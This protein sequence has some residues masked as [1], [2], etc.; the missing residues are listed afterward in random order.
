MDGERVALAQVA[1]EIVEQV[2]KTFGE[3]RRDPNAPIRP[4][5]KAEERQWSFGSVKASI[6][7]FE[8][9]AVRVDGGRPGVM[10][11]HM[12]APLRDA[13]VDYLA[14]RNDVVKTIHDGL[15]KLDL[16]SGQIEAPELNGHVFANKA[17]LLGAL[18]D[19]GNES[20]L[21]KRLLGSK[22]VPQPRERDGPI[23]TAPFWAFFERMI[24]DRKI[25]KADVDFLQLFWNSYHE[26]FERTQKVHFEVYGYQIPQLDRRS[27]QT[28]WG[29]YEGGYVPAKP[30][31]KQDPS[32]LAR[33][34]GDVSVH[35]TASPIPS[36]GRDFAHQRVEVNRSLV[37]NIRERVEHFDEHLRFLH[38]QKPGRQVWRLLQ[39]K[40]LRDE[41]NRIDPHIIPGIIR[42]WIKDTL[43]NRVMK[44]GVNRWLDKILV[45]IR[46]N[47]GQLYMMGNVANAA[48]QATGLVAAG[49]VA[50]LRNAKAAS[51]KFVSNPREYVQ[52]VIELSKFMDLRLVEQMGQIVDDIDVV[53]KPNLLS[54][55]QHWMSR[56]AYFLQRLIQSPVDVITWGA[57][58]DHATETGKS[59]KDAVQEA[60]SAVR[61]TQGSGL[62]PDLSAAERAGALGRM[63]TQFGSI[64]FVF[65]NLTLE[66]QT[67]P[68]RIQRFATLTAFM[69]VGAAAITQAL[70]GGWDDE[71][72]DGALMDDVTRWAFGEA[73]QSGAAIGAPVVGPMLS[74][75]L[76]DERSRGRLSFGASMGA[77]E[78]AGRGLRAS[79]QLLTDGTVLDSKPDIAREVK[80]RDIRDIFTLFG[81]LLGAPPA[82][83]VK[84]FGF[85]RDVERGEVQPTSDFDYW[86]GL[87]TGSASPGSR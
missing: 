21:R 76:F 54:R 32:A 53:L 29:V 10:H 42:P 83:A 34:D 28:P 85:L 1:G 43:L 24:E 39:N 77:I 15:N 7:H 49:F 13:H 14:E 56:N 50:P 47:V 57:V 70:R 45:T 9:F 18:L 27:F 87:V 16:P 65:W 66:G 23:N 46:R 64:W 4:L 37:S 38:M 74:R 35:D 26:R 31:P 86:R 69:G 67:T 79:F 72:A 81:L 41:L 25:T 62:A 80:G 20:N 60:D 30:D 48:Q 75:M 2:Q 22:W 51:A 52:R 17:E 11:K 63:L 8:S 61:R 44:P 59:Q 71:D 55:S 3:D 6:R 78:T 5:T 58:Y 36:T 73:V 12:F 33:G 82:A 19:M 68:L 40:E 84:P